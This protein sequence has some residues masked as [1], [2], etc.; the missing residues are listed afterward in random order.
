MGIGVKPWAVHVHSSSM[1][2]ASFSFFEHVSGGA[3]A[4]GS[5]LAFHVVRYTTKVI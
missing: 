3:V 2:V 5:R 1:L 4:I